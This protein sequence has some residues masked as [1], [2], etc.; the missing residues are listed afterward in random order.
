MCNKV[1]FFCTILPLSLILGAFA[2]VVYGFVWTNVIIPQEI[3][4]GFMAGRIPVSFKVSHVTCEGKMPRLDGGFTTFARDSPLFNIKINDS[5]LS[6][7]FGIKT[8]FT[9]GNVEWLP[10]EFTTSYE[11][12]CE[13]VDF[14]KCY[15]DFK[16]I[17]PKN[18][19]HDNFKC[20]DV[21]KFALAGCHTGFF[22]RL[23]RGLIKT[24][25]GGGGWTCPDLIV[26][27]D[28]V[29]DVRVGMTLSGD[30]PYVT[31]NNVGLSLALFAWTVLA[32]FFTV[33]QCNL[34][35]DQCMYHRDSGSLQSVTPSILVDEEIK[36]VVHSNNI[37]KRPIPAETENTEC[38]ISMEPIT[39]E[40]VQCYQC[41][42]NIGLTSYQ[43][44]VKLGQCKCPICRLE[45]KGELPIYSVKPN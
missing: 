25:R 34:W 37:T 38:V 11:S 4:K 10:D 20:S 9:C 27:T 40:Y 29:K 23:N 15:E 31:N 14:P 22:Y 26:Q 36:V 21:C 16:Y 13:F 5:A 33:G 3:N 43:S 42:K 32:F 41:H 2:G 12:L 1:A 17:V 44:L 6:E 28:D 7:Y 24:I 19:Q 8:P 35:G 45:W 39:A 30:A 18:R